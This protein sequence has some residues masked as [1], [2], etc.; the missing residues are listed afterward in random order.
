M[1]EM[2]KAQFSRWSALLEERTGMMLPEER[3]SF[4]VTNL[5]IRMREIGCADF[6]SYYDYLVSGRRGVV[7]WATLVDRLT[8]HETRFFRHLNSLDLLRD[9]FLPEWSSGRDTPLSMNIWSV[10][11]ATGEEAYTL[12]MVVDN[13]FAQPGGEYYIGVTGTDISLAS[14]AVGRR[15]EYDIRKLTEVDAGLLRRYMTKTGER[16]YRVNEDLRRRVCFAQLNVLDMKKAA[17]GMMDLIYCQNLLIYFNRERRINILNNLARHLN[18]GGLLVLGS[19]EILGW[20]HPDLERVS[21]EK[22]LAF[23]RKMNSDAT[24]MKGGAV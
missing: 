23:H 1:P 5:A 9:Y 7:E 3:R 24:A 15:G 12:A 6:E 18:P 13:H 11:C 20:D 17:V 14:L 19:G 10:G 4:L 16:H 8:V 21:Y 22:T 2:D